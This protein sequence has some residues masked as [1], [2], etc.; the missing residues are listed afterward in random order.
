MK[1]QKRRKMECKTDYLKRLILLKSEKPRIVFRKTNMYIIGQY[2]ESE[3]A[4]DKIIFGATSKMLFKYGWPEKLDGSLKSIPASYLTGYLVAKK[5]LKDKLKEPIVDLGMQRVIKKTKIFAFIKGLIDG[6]IK[7]KCDKENFP[8][9]ERLSGKSTKED[10][11]K[12]V[13]EVK[14]KIDKL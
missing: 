14:S 2:V 5:I 3:A 12:I 13:Q 4:Q 7:I 9:A 1:T 10:I 6:G 11:S 8:E